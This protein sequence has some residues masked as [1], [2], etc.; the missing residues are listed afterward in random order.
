MAS[1]FSGRRHRSLHNYAEIYS[2][3][4]FYFPQVKTLNVKQAR[5]CQLIAPEKKSNKK[6][7]I[8]N[9]GS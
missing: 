2:I 4:T 5:P 8:D 3:N 1:N 9:E 6:L 7:L